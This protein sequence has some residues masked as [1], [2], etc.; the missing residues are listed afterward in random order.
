MRKE[1]TIEIQMDH[2]GLSISNTVAQK[3]NTQDLKRAFV[4]GD[5]ARSNVKGNGLG[6]AWQIGQLMPVDL[7]YP[8]PVMIQLLER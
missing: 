4:R 1:G 2:N 7:V 6:L 5:E 8:Y 3:I